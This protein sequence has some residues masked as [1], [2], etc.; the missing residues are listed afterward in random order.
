MVCKR[1]K[2]KSGD[3]KSWWNNKCDDRRSISYFIRINAQK[4]RGGDEHS[5]IGSLLTLPV[6]FF[7]DPFTPLFAHLPDSTRI[8]NVSTLQGNLRN[9]RAERDSQ[10]TILEQQ[11][12]PKPKRGRTCPST[13]RYQAHIYRG[14]SD[15]PLQETAL[16]HHCTKPSFRTPTL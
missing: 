5:A 7:A 6:E 4:E 13:S 12:Y 3:N 9:D 10:R 15:V 1:F 2:E 11:M 14:L 16:I 8:A